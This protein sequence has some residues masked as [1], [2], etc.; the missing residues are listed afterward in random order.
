M[1]PLLERV[2]PGYQAAGGGLTEA[3]RRSLAAVER[4]GAQEEEARAGAGRCKGEHREGT[5]EEGPGVGESWPPEEGFWWARREDELG[6]R[7]GRG[8]QPTVPS[9]RGRAAEGAR[10]GRAEGWTFRL[11]G[12]LAGVD[13]RRTAAER[14]LG[15]R[16]QAMRGRIGR[17]SDATA[18][19]TG[20]LSVVRRASE[21]AH[22]RAETEHGVKGMFRSRARGRRAFLARRRAAVRGIG[23]QVA[24][25]GVARGRVGKRAVDVVCREETEGG[26]RPAM[27]SVVRRRGRVLSA[28]CEVGAAHARAARPAA[29]PRAS[30]RLTAPPPAPEPGPS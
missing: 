17:R 19:C 3:E 26:T 15:K 22:R 4:S 1:P 14:D 12:G 18:S 29:R 2:A 7:D 27:S 13:S 9:A 23:R 30:R 28:G 16:I 5:S 24:K 21:S 20:G 25:K 8:D 11:A 6:S 10:G